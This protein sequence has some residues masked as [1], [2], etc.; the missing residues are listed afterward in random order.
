MRVIHIVLNTL[1]MLVIPIR[2]GG[3]EEYMELDYNFDNR[4][5]IRGILSQNGPW[6]E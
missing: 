6:I 1:S 2:E 5:H 3:K 4:V